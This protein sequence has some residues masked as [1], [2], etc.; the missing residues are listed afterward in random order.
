MQETK[1]GYDR[2]FDEWGRPKKW[3]AYN[4]A[5]MMDDVSLLSLAA[6]PRPPV[7][8]EWFWQEPLSYRYFWCKASRRATVRRCTGGE[9][10]PTSM[11]NAGTVSVACEQRQLA[12]RRI[13]AVHP[14]TAW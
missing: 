5:D 11:L 9:S 7:R 3:W 2:F 1:G 13:V 14:R 12:P 10:K 4:I 8:F 6:M